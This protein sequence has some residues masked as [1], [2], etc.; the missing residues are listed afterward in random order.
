VSRSPA[1]LAALALAS[2][3]APS[4]CGLTA[5]VTYGDSVPGIIRPSD[6]GRIKLALHLDRFSVISAMRLGAE[7][8]REVIVVEPLPDTILGKVKHAC[9]GGGFCPDP[10]GF[11]ASRVRIVLLLD[12]DVTTLVVVQ[13]EALGP[14]GRLVDLRELGVAGDILGW[15][16]RPDSADGHVALSLTPITGIEGEGVGAGLDPPLLIRFNPPAGRFQVYDCMAGEDGQAVC[17]FKEEIGG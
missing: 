7:D 14:R 12:R 15:S 5:G 9:D 11:V 17:D 3:V 13:K 4:P 2:F 6:L 16:G 1:L 10:D 8:G